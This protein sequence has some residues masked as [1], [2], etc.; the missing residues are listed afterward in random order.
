[1]LPIISTH[2]SSWRCFAFFALEYVTIFL[3]GLSPRDRSFLPIICFQVTYHGALELKNLVPSTLSI[4][5][6]L[7]IRLVPKK[8][9]IIM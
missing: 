3:L 1:M 7:L 2:G 4:L 9:S 5:L 8:Q 6:V